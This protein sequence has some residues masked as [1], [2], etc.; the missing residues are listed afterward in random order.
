MNL[1]ITGGTGFFGKALLKYWAK[2]GCQFRKITILSRDPQNFTNVNSD[3]IKQ[4]DCEL[5][6]IKGDILNLNNL[7]VIDDFEY[8]L[9]AATDSTSG[10]TLTRNTHFE[11]IV[12]GTKSVLSFAKDHGCKK[13]LITSSGGIYG[14][15]P[16]GFS[17]FDEMYQGTLP[18]DDLNSAYGIGKRVAEHMS[19]LDA[20]MYSFDVVVAR[21]FAFIGEDLPLNK[22]FAIG[23]FI[24]DVL[25]DR[26]VLINGDG[27]PIRSYM[28]QDDLACW[29]NTM[30]LDTKFSGVFNIGSDESYCLLDIAKLIIKIAQKDLDIRTNGVSTRDVNRN[31]Y[32]PS[33]DKAKSYGLNLTF[34]LEESIAETLRRIEALR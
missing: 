3:L 18:V 14:K 16:D 2:H 34:S 32:V 24:N 1:F 20:S 29:L 13:F 26:N 33:I 22:H 23:N 15:L 21:C 12:Y 11:Q 5:S 6:F 30:L 25:S 4:L 19:F 17:C 31:I 10:P 28:M 27:T 9:H 7:P 8:V